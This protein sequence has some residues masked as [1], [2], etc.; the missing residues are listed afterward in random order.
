MA[1]AALCALMTRSWQKHGEPPPDAA[2]AGIGF[3][4]LLVPLYFVSASLLNQVGFTWLFTPIEQLLSH[5]GPMAIFNLLSPIVLLG[6]LIASL[7]LNLTVLI[8][9]SRR[10]GPTGSERVLE[11]RVRLWNLAAAATSLLLIGVLLGYAFL[12]NFGTRTPV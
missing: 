5:T 11:V 4:L 3:A 2:A 9:I 1:K 6:T 10:L 8:S 7:L 12:E